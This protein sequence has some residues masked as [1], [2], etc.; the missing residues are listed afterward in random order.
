MRGY[1]IDVEFN[2]RTLR[3]CGRGTDAR[4]ALAGGVNR[5]TLS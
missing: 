4:G 2:G 3:V 1:V 5:R